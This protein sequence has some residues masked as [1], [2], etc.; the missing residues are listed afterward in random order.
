MEDKNNDLS[1]L[2]DD[3]RQR[4]L[5]HRRSRDAG[6]KEL[7]HRQN[8]A[9]LD[10]VEAEMWNLLGLPGETRSGL[11][12]ALVAAALSKEAR[13]QARTHVLEANRLA[14]ADYKRCTKTMER[15]IRNFYGAPL[16][17]DLMHGETTET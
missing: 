5:A 10:S 13:K 11:I 16:R 17:P 3:L 14:V 7:V 1:N 9:F 8:L 15:N 4:I 6:L 12:V 2:S